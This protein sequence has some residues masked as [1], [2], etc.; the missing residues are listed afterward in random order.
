MKAVIMAGGL[1]AR[2]RP[3]TQI[4]PKPLLPVGEYSVIELIIKKLVACGFDEIFITTHYKSDLV[5]NFIGNGNKFGARIS[6]SREETPLGTCGPLHLIREHFK[7]PVLV[8]NGDILT[9]LNFS[10]VY[11]FHTEN[12]AD[13]TVVTKEFDTPLEYGIIISDGNK[14]SEIREKPNLKHEINAGIYVIS[15]AVLGMIPPN[16]KFLM[17]ELLQLMLAKKMNLLRYKTDCIWLDIG[18]LSDYKKA[19]TFARTFNEV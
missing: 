5:E 19:Q 4:I 11:L 17:T 6:F 14:V 7:E 8:I 2:L 18:R 13:L 1:G 12:Q 3:F 10:E 16:Q 9:N 15:P